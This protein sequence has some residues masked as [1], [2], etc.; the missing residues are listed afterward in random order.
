M[1][2]AICFLMALM[3][4]VGARANP[5]RYEWRS[6]GG[7][8]VDLQPLFAWW[9]FASATTNIP[10]DITVVDAAKLDAVSNTWFHLPTR[11]LA[12]WFRIS[13]NED[14]ITIVGNMWKVDAIVEPAPMMFKRQVIY[15]RNPPTKEIHDFKQALAQ[16]AA[17]QSG[18]SGPMA[19]AQAQ[20]DAVQTNTA[21]PVKFPGTVTTRNGVVVGATGAA[22]VEQNAAT[23]A[24]DSNV[25]QAA[26]TK[27]LADLQAYLALFPSTNM[28]SLDHFALRTGKVVDGLEVYDL[29]TAAGLN[30]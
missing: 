20:A 6:F 15:L 19:D 4:A 30:Y 7:A 27:S 13:A 1:K 5:N 8:N 29:G 12:D 22:A 11:P 25:A 21:S 10:L 18:Q 24:A 23:A 28:Y 9:T 3:L 26:T 16:Y 14:S 17:L 2:T